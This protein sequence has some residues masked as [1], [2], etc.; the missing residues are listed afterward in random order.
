[1]IC[2]ETWNIKS[3]K[4]RSTGLSHIISYGSHFIEN[5]ATSSL[6]WSVHL[7]ECIWSDSIEF[8]PH[9]WYCIYVFSYMLFIS[10]YFSENDWNHVWYKYMGILQTN[11]DIYVF[12]TR[13]PTRAAS[14]RYEKTCLEPLLL[15]MSWYEEISFL[16]QK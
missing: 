2:I 13:N 1:M 16:I 6:I 10:G 5:A 12:F 3:F 14:C 9:E 8:A 7:N 4:S 11:N 15:Y